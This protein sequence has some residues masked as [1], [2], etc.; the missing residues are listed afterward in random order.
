MVNGAHPGF[1]VC[2]VGWLKQW[3][4]G[5]DINLLIE[6]LGPTFGGY[7]TIMFELFQT[8]DGGLT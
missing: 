6:P 2:G 1:W 3:G 7:K 8:Y 5:D 4:R